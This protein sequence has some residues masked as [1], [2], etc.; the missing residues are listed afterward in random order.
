MYIVDSKH[1][2]FAFL[3]FFILAVKLKCL[4]H[5]KTILFTL[6]WLVLTAKKKKKYQNYINQLKDLT[7]SDDN[8]YLIWLHFFG[9]QTELTDQWL[10]GTFVLK[11][12]YKIFIS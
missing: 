12:S 9:E 5:M 8:P 11:I 4:Q 10:C 1:S 3:H 6:K 7:V 2:Y